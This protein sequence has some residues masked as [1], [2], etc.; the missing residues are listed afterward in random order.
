ME[1]RVETMRIKQ[2]GVLEQNGSKPQAYELLSK[3]LPVSISYQLLPLS[4][5]Q[6]VERTGVSG[7]NS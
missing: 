1:D 6:T 5:D 2:L 3:E 7:N 4:V